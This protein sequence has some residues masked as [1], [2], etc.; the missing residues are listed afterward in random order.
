MLVRYETL[1]RLHLYHDTRVVKVLD[2]R[3]AVG[4]HRTANDGERTASNAFF[5]QKLRTLANDF[6]KKIFQKRTP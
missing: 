4:P 3:R 2:D 6:G 1:N 5:S